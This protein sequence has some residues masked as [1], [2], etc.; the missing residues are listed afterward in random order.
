MPCVVRRPR[1]V[2][3]L[4][5]HRKSFA[6]FRTWNEVLSD[7]SDICEP[8]H[9]VVVC[10]GLNNS[11][12]LCRPSGWAGNVIHVAVNSTLTSLGQLEGYL[13]TSVRY[14]P[15]PHHPTVLTT[16]ETVNETKV[17]QRF[18]DGFDNAVETV[19]QSLLL[20]ARVIPV[21][22]CFLVG[23]AASS[24]LT[25]YLCVDP[26][27]L[28][29]Q[30][31]TDE[32]REWRFYAE[33]SRVEPAS[34]C[35][36]RLLS[37]HSMSP[38]D[39]LFVVVLHFSV[40]A[41]CSFLDFSLGWVLS[42]IRRHS[43]PPFDVTGGN[44]L[45]SVVRGNG[46]L[47]KILKEFLRGFHPGHWFGFFDE[48][49]ACMPASSAPSLFSLSVLVALYGV[50][51]AGVA[52]K[53]RLS[54]LRS[55][56]CGQFYPERELARSECLSGIIRAKRTRVLRSIK[57]AAVAAS[58]SSAGTEQKTATCEGDLL[59]QLMDLHADNASGSICHRL[60]FQRVSLCIICR[61]ST[62]THAC[63]CPVCQQLDPA[64]RVRCCDDCL[65]AIES[66]AHSPSLC[67]GSSN[68]YVDLI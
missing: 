30:W 66:N 50:L 57:A 13:R 56:I 20:V 6:L 18:L 40:T 28:P 23:W 10:Q 64:A 25:L 45:A 4:V 14:G 2:V 38:S 9:S 26:T 11:D 36:E 3:R 33:Q 52:L 19:E 34:F 22:A 8:L 17:R 63:P 1:A 68:G 65:R 29:T 43:K 49:F 31:L 7:D 59:R 54:L 41:V 58:S 47:A 55:A 5:A 44:S 21:I 27:Y 12:I 37:G 39:G 67:R 24:Y 61:S 35:F 46:T 51:I 16:G 48:G 32:G 62:A 42:L 53:R 60:L 15:T